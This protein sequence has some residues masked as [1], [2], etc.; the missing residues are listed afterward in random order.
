MKITDVETYLVDAGWPQHNRVTNREEK[1][2]WSARNWLFVKICTDEGIYGIGEASGWPRVVET[3]INDLAPLL[4]NEDPFHIERIWHKMLASIMGHGMT[5][6]V[7]GG[8]I[9]GIEMALWDLK[10]KAL[11]QP[12]WNLFGGKMR[13]RVR[14]YGHASSREQARSLVD[15]GYGA[16]KTGGTQN[17]LETLKSIRQEV[18]KDVDL[19]V[20][21]HG[22]PWLNTR[23]AIA[24][25]KRLEE[26]DLLFYEDPVAPENIEAISRVSAAVNLPIAAGERHATIW[27]VRE[28]IEREIIDVVQPDT[29][30]AGGL[31][32]MKKIA[33]IA[34]AHYCT[35]APHDGSLGPVAE[36]AAVHLMATIPNFLILEHLAND[37]PQRYSIMTGQ[38]EV[39]NGHITV[40]N[41]PGLGIDLIEEEISR[42]PSAGNSNH[43]DPTY[44]YQYVSTKTGRASWLSGEETNQTEYKAGQVF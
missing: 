28:L 10:G 16:I 6:V 41:T 27:G 32:Q 7:G 8:A 42:Y 15:Q 44:G 2:G 20:D 13:D 36:M 34:E 37:V 4:I 29:G 14:I 3:A 12:V 9:T 21:I 39:T 31:M 24:L 18:G 35:I 43:P 5:G 40:P 30:R 17:T 23:D 25:G 38:P 11:G 22:P 1:G 19:M 33:A 26:Y